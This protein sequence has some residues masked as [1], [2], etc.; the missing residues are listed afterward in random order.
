MIRTLLLFLGLAAL[1]MPAA[2]A[3]RRY[4]VTDF[5]RVVVE[6]PYVVRLTVGGPSSAVATGPQLGIDRLL[7]DVSGTTL[8]IRRNRNAWGGPMGQA[9][10]QAG[11]VE[12]ALSTRNLRSVRVV[13]PGR[14]ELSGARGLQLDL[15]LEG[16]GEIRATGLDVDNLALGLRGSGRLALAGRAGT[17]RGDFQGTGEVEASALTA[18]NVTLGS[19]LLGP[20]VLN[21]NRTA[22]ITNN[23]LGEVT[24]GGR[25]ACTL[26]GPGASQVRCGEPTGR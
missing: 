16:S 1:A 24:V 9:G 10:A 14:V 5:D 23:G 7:V 25:P 26:T 13:G 20:V 18:E 2:A 22:R 21:A 19:T 17:V 3:E 15:I 12:V 6:G 4:S 8:R 11:I